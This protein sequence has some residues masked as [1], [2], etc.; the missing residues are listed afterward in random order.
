MTVDEAFQELT[1][2]A[3]RTLEMQRK[4]IEAGVRIIDLMHENAWLRDPARKRE[5]VQF[6]LEK[7]SSDMELDE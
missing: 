5:A 3:H 4:H 1:E 6:I 7:A 2:G